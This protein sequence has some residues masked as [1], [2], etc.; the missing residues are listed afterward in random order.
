MESGNLETLKRLV[1]N[2]QG[3]TLLPALAVDDLRGDHPGACIIPFADPVPTR[4]VV[5]VR[6]RIHLKRHLVDAFL[7]SLRAALPPAV[8]TIR[9]PGVPVEGGRKQYFANLGLEGGAGSAGSR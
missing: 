7:E 6:R 9:P 5:L 1:E 3:F 8:R 4:Q 2:G